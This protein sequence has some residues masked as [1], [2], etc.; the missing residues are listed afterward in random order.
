MSTLEPAI[1]RIHILWLCKN[2][3]LLADP[4][5][6]SVLT[7]TIKLCYISQL[8][9][10]AITTT[11]DVVI[12]ACLRHLEES[13]HAPPGLFSATMENRVTVIDMY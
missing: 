4:L 1:F 11:V 6:Y 2:Y 7:V 10:S 8:P 12:S 9:T 5:K 13:A 3:R